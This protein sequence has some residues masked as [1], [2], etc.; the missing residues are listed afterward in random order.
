[1][2]DQANDEPSDELDDVAHELEVAA[3]GRLIEVTSAAAAG[4]ITEYVVLPMAQ[5]DVVAGGLTPVAMAALGGA[6]ASL[7][8]QIVSRRAVVLNE[9][10]IQRSAEVQDLLEE[11]QRDEDSLL[12]F[13]R[14]MDSA[15]T[16]TSRTKLVL[17]GRSL[18]TSLDNRGRDEVDIEPLIL[19]ALSDID[20]LHAVVLDAFDRLSP[21]YSAVD[22]NGASERAVAT[23]LQLSFS[24][25]SVALQPV[26]Q[27]LVRH[28]LISQTTFGEGWRY[29]E[30]MSEQDR[31]NAWMLT[32]FGLEVLERIRAASGSEGGLFA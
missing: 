23:D 16:T 14:A 10:A 9:A 30:S 31:S 2:E 12:A 13:G 28:G 7:H 29:E 26:V 5:S 18:A 32:T 11:V 24:S 25:S 15:A 17:L 8:S 1:M 6:V 22:H 19:A 20:S 27:V 21:A 3:G 4:A